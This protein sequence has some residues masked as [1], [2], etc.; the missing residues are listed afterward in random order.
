MAIQV[1]PRTAVIAGV[2]VLALAGAGGAYFF[3]FEDEP[4]PPV[5]AKPPA[6]PDKVAAEAGKPPAA[7]AGAGAK[8]AAKPIPQ[9]PDLVIAEVIENSGI[10]A[11]FGNFG[12]EVMASAFPPG[13]TRQLGFSAA[14]Q[15]TLSE[16]VGRIFEPAKMAAEFAANL[17]AGYDPVRMPR[18][19]ELL[20]EPISL[21]LSAQALRE[22]S[23][24]AVREFSESFRKEPPP[25]ERVKRVELIDEVTRASEFGAELAAVMARDM[26]DSMLNAMQKAGKQVPKEARQTLGTQL[27]TIRDQMRTNIRMRL[28]VIYGDVNDEELA[29]YVKLLDTETGRWGLEVLANA[30]KPV[31]ASRAPALGREIAQ[32]ALASE[33]MRAKAPAAAK[34]LAKVETA[35]PAPAPAAP[36]EP[37]AYRRPEGIKELYSRYN[38]LITAVVMRDR[39]AVRELLADGKSPNARQGDGF[40]ALMIAVSNGD[41]ETAQMLLAKGADPNLSAPGGVTALSLARERRAAELTKLLERHGVKN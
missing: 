39:T 8:P 21:K 10:K 33:R 28:H 38:D 37:P 6:A 30:T 27:Q 12:R 1:N 23:P 17:R 32:L 35:A 20:R 7:K 14:E 15:Q 11:S 24:E 2:A 36:A 9:N 4:P 34:A 29:E 41:L 19:L 5:A 3:L 13:Q 18:L 22:V 31:M 25:P 40:T 26:I 16:A